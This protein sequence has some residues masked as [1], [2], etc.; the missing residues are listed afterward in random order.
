MDD[1]VDK[2]EDSGDEKESD[3]SCMQLE[4]SV[5]HELT[6]FGPNNNDGKNKAFR[7]ISWSPVS[8]IDES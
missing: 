5:N 2:S 6:E 8:V 1:Q 7:K 4:D 3:G